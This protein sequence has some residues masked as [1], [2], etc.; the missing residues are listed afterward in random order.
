ML[1]ATK[2]AIENSGLKVYGNNV[3]I[4]GNLYPLPLVQG[5]T[6]LGLNVWHSSTLPTN[7]EITAKTAAGEIITECGTCPVTCK[8][9]YGTTGNY[10]FNSSKY[11]IMMRTKLLKNYPDIYFQL[12]SIQIEHE[13]I[14]KLRIHAV[15]DFLPGEALGFYNVLKKFP[16]VKA[17]TYTKC[18]VSGDIALLGTLNN[19]NV[20]KSIIPGCGF[21][22]GHVAY[23]ANL[24]YKLKRENKSVYI[25]RCGIDENQHCSNCS[26]CSDHEYVLFI[27]HSTGYNAKTDYGYKK[28]V[29]MIENQKGA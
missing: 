15:G 20:V 25:C 27:E 13:N 26:G 29:E 16:D 18:K 4:D 24:F 10:R 7:K 12:V 19:C 17:W 11:V 5:N 1:T 21:N 22:F 6:K 28:I 23:I 8:G 9:C 14:E 2:K 3:M